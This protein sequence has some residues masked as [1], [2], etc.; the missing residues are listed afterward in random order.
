[1]AKTTFH[2]LLAHELQDLFDAESRILKALP[3]LMEKA[4]S[5][6][7]REGFEKHLKQT[8]GQVE[9]LEKCFKLLDIAERKEPC[10]GM[11]GILEEGEEGMKKDM[12]PAVMD[13]ALIA[14]AQRVEHYEMAAYG[15]ACAWAKLMGHTEVADLLSET[16][17]E[18]KETD[19]ILSKL[20]ESEI[21]PK[22]M[23]VDPGMN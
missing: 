11:K 13:A 21:N 19:E 2:S 20:A 6:K 12:E 16:L 4:N 14:G 10:S 23:E 1:M 22:A 15:T 9:R 8:E 3:K 7:L 5:P 18:E 17:E